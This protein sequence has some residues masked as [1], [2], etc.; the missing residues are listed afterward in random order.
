MA[1]INV[2]C[3]LCGHQMTLPAELNGQ[4]GQCPNCNQAFLISGSPIGQPTGGLGQPLPPPLPS[5][6]VQHTAGGPSDFGSAAS[7]AFSTVFEKAKSAAIDSSNKKSVSGNARYPNLSK[8]LSIVD[9]VI[10]VCFWIALVLWSI[11]LILVFVGGIME[12]GRDAGE[13]IGMILG[14]II[15]APLI[16]LW[17]L[18]CRLCGYASSELIRVL[19][20][21]EAN[22]RR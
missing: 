8:Y 19:M 17:L 2:S 6:S 7:A 16:F 9:T 14:A 1:E 22:T 3:P 15:G 10:K 12:L 20:D 11:A 13:G 18:F 21:I 5:A 4:R